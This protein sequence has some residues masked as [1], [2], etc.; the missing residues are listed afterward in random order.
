MRIALAG[1][2]N[3]GKT[4]LFNA[5]TGSIESVGNWPGVT[6]ARKEGEVK[7]S[8]YKKEEIIRII[9]LPGTY[10]MS[11]FTLEERI[12]RDF[13]VNEHPDVI[14]NIIDANNLSRSLVYTTQLLELGVPVVVAL[15]KWDLIRSKQTDIS[16]DVLSKQLN[17]PVIPIAAIQN[18]GLRILIETC[19]SVKGKKQTAPYHAPIATSIDRVAEVDKHRFEFVE[20]IVTEAEKRKSSSEKCRY[21]H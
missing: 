6:V 18:Q 14:I 1:N 20:T 11:P 15:N 13:V 12:T 10:S 5:I 21:R 17:C 4:T 2:P 9:D 7:R 19:I 8:L 3:S 16:V